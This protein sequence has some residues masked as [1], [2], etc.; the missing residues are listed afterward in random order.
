ML[1]H[2]PIASLTL[3]PKFRNKNIN[4]VIFPRIQAQATWTDQL[5][6]MKQIQCH[7]DVLSL[8]ARISH[9]PTARGLETC[10][11]LCGRQV[12]IH[13]LIG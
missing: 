12:C 13:A 11:K 8:F 3:W 10:G 5:L 6:N 2:I 4:F 1:T 9:I 7:P